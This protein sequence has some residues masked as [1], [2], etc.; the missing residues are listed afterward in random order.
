MKTLKFKTNLCEQILN[1][2]K[3]STWRLFDDKNLQSGDVLEFINKDTGQAFGTATIT[4]AYIRTLSTLENDDW[5]GHETFTSDEEMYSVFRS[6][7]GDTVDENTEVKIL[8]FT[9][10]PLLPTIAK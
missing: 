7:Y 2:E 8:S 3:T 1:G 4:S 10:H 5:E 9:F 6:Y